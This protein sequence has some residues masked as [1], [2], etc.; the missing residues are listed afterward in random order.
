MNLSRN[1]HTT[2][3]VCEVSGRGYWT[4]KEVRV[5]VRPAA[6]DTGILL[7]RTDLPDHPSCPATTDYRTDAKLRTNIANGDAKFEMIEHLM[8]ALY[9]M[10]IDNCVVE[11]DGIEFPGLDGSS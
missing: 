5:V 7:V 8:A 6:V 11:I 10:E 2:A 4:A 9:A 3:S 1:Q